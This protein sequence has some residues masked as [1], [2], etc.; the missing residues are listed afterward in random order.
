M[1]GVSRPSSPLNMLSIN[2]KAARII[3]MVISKGMTASSP[4]K[5][6]RQKWLSRRW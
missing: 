1:I 5:M 2:V 6:R 3:R 4:A